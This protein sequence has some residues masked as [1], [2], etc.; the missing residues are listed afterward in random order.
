MN[1]IHSAGITNYTYFTKV[2]IPH[3][4][5]YLNGNS[6]SFY[7]FHHRTHGSFA[8]ALALR[9]NLSQKS[10]DKIFF[11]FFYK[12]ENNTYTHC[13][14]VGGGTE[15]MLQADLDRIKTRSGDRNVHCSACFHPNSLPTYYLLDHSATSLTNHKYYGFTSQGWKEHS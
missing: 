2:N 12:C 7:Q 9:N 14:G 5:W 8:Y 3:F 1:L 11:L 15:G 10:Q 6:S 4:K 13:L